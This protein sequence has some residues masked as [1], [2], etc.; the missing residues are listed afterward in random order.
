MARINHSNYEAWLLDQLEGRLTPAQVRELEAFLIMHPELRPSEEPMPSLDAVR[1]RLQP[2][3]KDALKRNLPP[4]GLVS[5]TTVD[6][7]LVARLEGD[8]DPEQEEALKVF[9]EANREHDRDARLLALTRVGGETI[10]LPEKAGLHRALPPEG[11]VD[12]RSLDDHL[13]ARMEGDLAPE[14]EQALAAHLAQHANAQRAWNL[15]QA[16]RI[17][18]E[19]IP[20]PDKA[21]LKRGGQVIPLFPIRGTVRWAAA[22]SVALLL[23][24]AWWLNR[25]EPLPVADRTA[26][27]ETSSPTKENQLHQA[28]T[29]E[30]S[31]PES[32]VAEFGAGPGVERA[33]LNAPHDEQGPQ[34]PM[35]HINDAPLEEAPLPE[36]SPM[37][38]VHEPA[39]TAA[40]L[41]EEPL[42]EPVSTTLFAST[43][44]AVTAARAD[45]RTLG[46]AIASALRERVLERPA[47]ET[48]PLDAD[49]AV[50][51]LDR[52]L[53]A[54]GGDR[55]GV[56]VQRD[57]DGRGNGFALRLGRN[58]A[59]T[60]SR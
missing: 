12:A 47:E 56:A 32:P 46:Q 3:E 42:A 44:T 9:L 14:Q 41:G 57:A 24:A 31:V 21:G 8:L 45:G 11:L 51:A 29:P 54:V 10:A 27:S 22:A 37:A 18:A 40:V 13:V 60:A 15:M 35:A 50:A 33:R 23:A 6:D 39:P 17:A 26:P 59:F 19:S 1:A 49:D 5:H 16:A 48:R 4:I 2:A 53:R 38:H 36:P 25:P 30:E 55:S 20:F 52:G 7:H 43:P 58:L 28:A 34:Q